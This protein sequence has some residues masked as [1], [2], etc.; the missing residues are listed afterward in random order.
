MLTRLTS[1]SIA[2]HQARG[3][4]RARHRLIPLSTE[5]IELTLSRIISVIDRGES[6]Q[7]IAS[8][9]CHIS[10]IKLG[11]RDV[12]TRCALVAAAEVMVAAGRAASFL[13]RFDRWRDIAGA[14]L[15]APPAFGALIKSR[16]RIHFRGVERAL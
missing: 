1:V 15:P 4:D 3:F 8:V 14:K 6:R 12:S 7:E 2:H 9:D 16:A 13:E 5:I 10:V 11:R